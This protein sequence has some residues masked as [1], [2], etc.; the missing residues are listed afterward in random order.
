[1][2]ES[3]EFWALRSSRSQDNTRI[4]HYC[5]EIDTGASC[6][7]ADRLVP[8]ASMVLGFGCSNPFK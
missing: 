5:D 4:S 6:G 1:M 2:C 7:S 3:K 8:K